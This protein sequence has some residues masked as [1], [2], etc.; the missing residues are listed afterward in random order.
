LAA[1]LITTSER[2][3][4]EARAHPRTRTPPA[5]PLVKTLPKTQSPD[6]GLAAS[7]LT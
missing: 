1:A 7:V 5:C 6:L 3:L 2:T 4:T